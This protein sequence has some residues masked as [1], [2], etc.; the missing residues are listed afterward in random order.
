MSEFRVKT[1]LP[2]SRC[3]I[4]HQSDQFDAEKGYCA[5]C[6]NISINKENNSSRNIRKYI[7]Q[8]LITKKVAVSFN[9]SV[10]II[11][12]ALIFTSYIS[13]ISFLLGL[14]LSY[15]LASFYTYTTSSLQDVYPWIKETPKFSQTNIGEFINLDHLKIEQYSFEIK[16][17]G[18]IRL[19]DY[20]EDYSESLQVFSRIFFHPK[21]KCFATIDQVFSI[22]KE[23]LPIALSIS[24]YMEE[25]WSLS[26]TKAINPILSEQYIY[27][28]PKRLW[29][30]YPENSVKE[31][32]D[33]HIIA[34]NNILEK[35]RINMLVE[36]NSLKQ[37][38]EINLK[39]AEE[40]REKQQDRKL[41][42]LIKDR[43]LLKFFP[44]NKWLDNY[45]SRL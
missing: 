33:L 42:S 14:V 35:L 34:R 18:F 2:A 30:N 45:G 12:A 39:I 13:S 17:L 22:N 32:L 11:T 37:F 4:C 26:S 25:G 16:A 43:V 5:R 10:V 19:G 36:E 41:I 6:E 9:T 3:E 24:S 21:Y 1:E 31:I 40:F 38:L 8:D 23:P 27:R 7:K 20:K 44:K 29:I 28:L 15:I